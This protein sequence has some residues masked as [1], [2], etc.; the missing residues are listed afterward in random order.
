MT[1]E[2]LRPVAGDQ[3]L[4]VIGW[5]VEQQG[6]KFFAGT[7]LVDSHDQICARSLQVWIGSR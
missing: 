6:K 5:T 2:V 4:R 7:A 3:D 1:G